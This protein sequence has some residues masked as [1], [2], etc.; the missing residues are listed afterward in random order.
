MNSR[1]LLILAA[2]TTSL[3]TQA[4]PSETYSREA[5]VW[6]TPEEYLNRDP[7]TP[8]SIA[9]QPAFTIQM[10]AFR[11]RESA[12][13]KA[14]TIASANVKVQRTLRNGENWYL[15]LL[16]AYATR[17]DAHEAEDSYLASNPG[18]DTWIRA[19]PVALDR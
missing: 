1:C 17:V 4:Q 6:P 7:G 15:V 18:A 5:P 19:M 16:G 3:Y 14:A 11:D 13:A 10:G 9:V 2:L 12:L 8:S